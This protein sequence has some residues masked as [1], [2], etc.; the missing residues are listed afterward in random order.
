M[1]VDLFSMGRVESWGDEAIFEAE[2]YK[3]NFKWS[4]RN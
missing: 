3:N 4:M 1:S 2:Y